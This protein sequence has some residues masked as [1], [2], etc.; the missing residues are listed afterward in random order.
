MPIPQ[1]GILGTD[2]SNAVLAQPILELATN[3][4][5]SAPDRFADPASLNRGPSGPS[6]LQKTVK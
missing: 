1:P 3:G 2:H 4:A 6:H 5:T